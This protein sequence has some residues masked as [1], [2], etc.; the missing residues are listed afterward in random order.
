MFI[1][2]FLMS[3]LRNQCTK[4]LA[5]SKIIKYA[6]KRSTETQ[7]IIRNEK[8]LEL[9]QVFALAEKDLNIMIILQP[10]CLQ[11]TKFTFY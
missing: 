1:Q 9:T 10:M 2:Y 4:Y 3:N 11:R 5:L 6:K 7:S 8:S